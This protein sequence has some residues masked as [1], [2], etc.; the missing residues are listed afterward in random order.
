[1][2]SWQEHMFLISCLW[3]GCSDMMWFALFIFTNEK[4]GDVYGRK[5]LHIIYNWS[6][7]N[8]IFP[9]ETIKIL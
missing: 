3:W 6:S 4:G 8:S 5:R 9:K 7:I 2:F 1:M